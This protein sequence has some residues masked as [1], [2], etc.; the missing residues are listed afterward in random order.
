MLSILTIITIVIS[1]SQTSFHSQDILTLDRESREG[2]TI[3]KVNKVFTIHRVYTIFRLYA[4]HRYTI[5][6]VY[7][8]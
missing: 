7:T 1:G 8:L 6:N 4:V 2:W 3:E 5:Y